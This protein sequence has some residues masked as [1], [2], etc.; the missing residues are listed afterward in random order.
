MGKIIT[1]TIIEA[2]HRKRGNSYGAE[3]YGLFATML[4]AILVIV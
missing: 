4:V 2:L 1:D 3:L